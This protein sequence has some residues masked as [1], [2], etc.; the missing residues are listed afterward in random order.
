MRESGDLGLKCMYHG[1]S[2]LLYIRVDLVGKVKSGAFRLA[3]V[4]GSF[5]VEFIF[6]CYDILKFV[7][8]FFS[9]GLVVRNLYRNRLLTW[10]YIDVPL[11]CSKGDQELWRSSS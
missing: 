3:D 5:S 7:F 2:G 10:D 11:L 4:C 1:G 9:F 6:N 8:F